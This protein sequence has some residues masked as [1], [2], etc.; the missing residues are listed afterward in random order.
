MIHHDRG[1]YEEALGKYEQSLR[2]TEELGDGAGIANSSGQISQLYVQLGRYAEG[3]G[4]LVSAMLTF[5]E[6]QSPDARIASA[7]LKDLRSK[8][9][10]DAFDPQWLELVGSEVPHWLKE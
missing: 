2:I 4:Y 10:A 3:L 7:L 9:G 8:W 1:E 6:L 5:V